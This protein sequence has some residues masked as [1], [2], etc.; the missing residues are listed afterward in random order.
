M[1]ETYK[2]FAYET[3][4]LRS[5][6]GGDAILSNADSAEID[7]LTLTQRH[8]MRQ[9]GYVKDGT[10]KLWRSGTVSGAQWARVSDNLYPAISSYLTT[11]ELASVVSSAP[12]GFSLTGDIPVFQPKPRKKNVIVI[13]DSISAGV[14]TTN[15]LLDSPI[16]QAIAD[17]D[18]TA[19]ENSLE[20]NDRCFE[21]LVWASCNLALGGSSWGN[22]NAGG[23]DAVYPKRFDLAWNQ[24]FRTLCLNGEEQVA[25]HIWLGTN[26][27]SYDTGLSA[28]QVWARAET[29]IG[30][31]RAEFPSVPII[32]GTCIRRTEGSP[33]NTRIDAY[34]TLLRA[35]YATIG[36]D[37]YV[38]YATAHPSFDPLTGNSGDLTVYA[39]DNVHPSTAGAGHLATLLQ[40]KL[41]TV[42]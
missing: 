18:P 17:L 28:A 4:N 35:N 8:I 24:R 37:D 36:A 31:V 32:M 38:D 23:G 34:N 11:A 39:G 15:D 1:A 29:H 10:D 40:A 16:A 6:Y 42:F 30:N 19:I 21:G 22:T 12:V 41:N 2:Y 33:L 13:G 5:E 20:P 14:S 9:L 27:L 3:G 7:S 26:D 25:L